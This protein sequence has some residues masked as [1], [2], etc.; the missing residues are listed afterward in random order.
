MQK[1]GNAV[2]DL[3]NALL[4]LGNALVHSPFLSVIIVNQKYRIVWCNQRFAEEFTGGQPVRDGLCFETIGAEKVH[5]NCPLQT[6]RIEKARTKGILDF[7]D[8][9]FLFLT[10]PLDEDHAAKVHLYI[11][12]EDRYGIEQA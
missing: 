7:G 6:S 2:F 3:D 11:P 1:E 5:A 4:T 10:I 9:D 12:K 8:R